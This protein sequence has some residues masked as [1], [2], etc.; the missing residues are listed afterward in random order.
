METSAFASFYQ[1]SEVTRLEHFKDSL[2]EQCELAGILGTIILSREGVNGSV[3]GSDTAISSLLDFMAK[4]LK[5]NDLLINRSLTAAKPFDR[6]VVR[7]KNEI[8]TSGFKHKTR[9][10]DYVEPEEWDTFIKQEDVI[11]VD[12]RNFYEH[13]IGSFTDAVRPEIRNFRQFPKFVSQVLEKNKNKKLAIF[14]TGGIRCEKASHFLKSSGFDKVYQLKGG[15]F[16]YFVKKREKK[17]SLWF[18]DCFVFDKRLAVDKNFETIN[19]QQC[20]NC[21]EM[22]SKRDEPID[23]IEWAVCAACTQI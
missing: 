18:G 1:F 2:L 13:S 23:D 9:S 14:C 4:I 10:S 19:Y 7:I 20:P 3:V 12:V 8:V 16:N 5:F 21:K 15:I 17:N 6:L 22:I 11:T